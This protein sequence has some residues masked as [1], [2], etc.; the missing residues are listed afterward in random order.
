MDN[1]SNWYA[2]K[3][4]SQ[5]ALNLFREYALRSG[6]ETFEAIQ[7]GQVLI[8][9]LIFVFCTLQWAIEARNN[10]LFQLYAYCIPGTN[11]P[12]VI[13][14]SDM[15]NFRLVLLTG[16]KLEPVENVELKAGDMARVIEGPFKGIEGYIARVR[17]AK[18]LIISLENVGAFSTQYIPK[19]WC[20][21]L[22]QDNI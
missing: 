19:D 11:T 4:H 1:K 20:R 2:F 9:N 13:R 18:R 16:S 14:T 12:A 21:K 17:N 7:D 22:K 5:G 8:P 15:N 10:T 3:V 6:Q